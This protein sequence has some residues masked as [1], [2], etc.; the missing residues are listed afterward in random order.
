MPKFK[1]HFVMEQSMTIEAET[2]EDAEDQA[3]VDPEAWSEPLLVE[4]EAI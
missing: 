2:A 4:V 3:K 1:V